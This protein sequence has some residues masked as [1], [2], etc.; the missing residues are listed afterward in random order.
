MIEFEHVS[1]AVTSWQG[2]SGSSTRT[3][4]DGVHVDL[5]EHRVAVIGANGSGK[6]TLLRLINGLVRPTTGRVLVD[7]LDVSRQ[8]SQVR[9]RVGFV[10]ADPL[11]QLVMPTPL[12]DIE[13]GLHRRIK[14][15]RGRRAHAEQV[16]TRHGLD[17][18]ASSSIYDLSGGERQLVA[19]A[20]VLAVRPQVVVADEPTTLLDLRN[21]R[22]LQQIL[23]DLPQQLIVATHDLAF[24]AMLDRGLVVDGGRIVFDGAAPDAVHR[25]R[26]LCA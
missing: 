20:G 5:A 17:A 11:S 10:F 18:V 1:V 13:L 3:V 22:R 21:E 26:E 12:E 6:S 24:A 19:L 4:L 23:L 15:R 7:G 9:E 14:D 2:P 16:L 25:Y 8:T